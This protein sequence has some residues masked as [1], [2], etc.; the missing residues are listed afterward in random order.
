MLNYDHEVKKRRLVTSRIPA[1]EGTQ[2]P[3]TA[4]E[5]DQDVRNRLYNLL[6]NEDTNKIADSNA[7]ISASNA[8]LHPGRCLKRYAISLGSPERTKYTQKAKEA[9]RVSL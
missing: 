7:S 4:R 5:K 1:K 6:K 8:E 9:F 2:W 3:S